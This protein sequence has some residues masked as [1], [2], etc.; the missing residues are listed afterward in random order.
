MLRKVRVDFPGAIYHVINRSDHLERIFRD[1]QDRGRPI[2]NL[3]G[4]CA[5]TSW[6]VLT[7]CLMLNHFH[8]FVETP[9][10]NLLAAGMIW[11]L[12]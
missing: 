3:A 9:Q 7:F 10:H 1:D 11:F 2:E 4:V 8:L 12:V 5:R 6:Q